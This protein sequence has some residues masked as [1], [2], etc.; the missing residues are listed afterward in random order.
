MAYADLREYI[1][2]LEKKGKL[3][4]VKKEVDKDWDWRPCVGSSSKKFPQKRPR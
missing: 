1:A 2:A 4:R 3:K